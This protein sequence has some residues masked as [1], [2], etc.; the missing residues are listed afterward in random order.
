MIITGGSFKLK[1]GVLGVQC[2][3]VQEKIISGIIMHCTIIA[4]SVT[5]VAVLAQL[6]SQR[7]TSI[8]IR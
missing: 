5:L 8:P 4:T 2:H 7:R 1:L 3:I 6:L